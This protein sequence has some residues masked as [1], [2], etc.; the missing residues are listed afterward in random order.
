[1]SHLRPSGILPQNKAPD[2]EIRLVLEPAEILTPSI[3][4]K[5]DVQ[6]TFNMQPSPIMEI[7]EFLDTPTK[8]MFGAGWSVSAR[9]AQGDSAVEVTYRHHYPIKNSDIDSILIHANL[10]GFNNEPTGDSR[11]FKAQVE[12][13]YEQKMLSMTT[14]KKLDG[15]LP[16]ELEFPKADNLRQMITRE[17]PNKFKH[18]KLH[19]WGTYALQ[20]S[21][22]HGPIHVDRYSGSWDG[23]PIGLEV[24]HMVNSL[25]ERTDYIVELSFKANNRSSA[26]SKQKKLVDEMKSKGWL[27][28]EDED[29]VKT[30][31]ILDA[32]A[33]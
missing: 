22:I 30:G 18:W 26:S 32:Y 13:G 10:Q 7:I 15:F 31:A 23:K 6:S 4:L 5:N 19:D 3:E 2:Y 28:V 33:F 16:N 21:V 27:V 9:K 14:K 29:L 11:E 1:M 24:W 8:E 25:A 12:W 20:R 17:A